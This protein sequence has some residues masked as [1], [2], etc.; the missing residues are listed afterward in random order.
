MSQMSDPSSSFSHPPRLSET[1]HR[2]HCSYHQLRTCFVWFAFFFSLPYVG[3]FFTGD[4]PLCLVFGFFRVSVWFQ[5]G[6][7]PPD[8]SVHVHTTPCIECQIWLCNVCTGA[9]S[10]HLLTRH[11]RTCIS[12]FRGQGEY[13][14][15]LY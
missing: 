12:L 9:M 7:T 4:N 15:L 3:R 8:I 6:F 14:C 5:G 10:L 11:Q 2:L 1:L 13:E